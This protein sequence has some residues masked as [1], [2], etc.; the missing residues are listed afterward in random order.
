MNPK[1]FLQKATKETKSANT[2]GALV[3]LVTFCSKS[4]VL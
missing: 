1:P 3:P 4:D 2:D